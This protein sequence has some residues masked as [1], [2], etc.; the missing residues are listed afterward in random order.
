LLLESDDRVDR[1]IA[2]WFT[3]HRGTWRG[4]ATE[5]IAALKTGADGACDSYSQPAGALYAH[6]QSH[7]QTLR[8]LGVDVLLLA[9]FPRMVSL[10]PC[11][12][13]ERAKSS[14]SDASAS[15]DFS[16]QPKPSPPDAG[17]A[18]GHMVNDK[19]ADGDGSEDHVFENSADVLFGIVQMQNGIREQ[20]LDLKSAM[21]WVAVRAQELTG[22]SGV[23]V[24]LLQQDTVVFPA[25]V[26]IAVTMAGLP[27]L[28]NL[29]QSCIQNGGV[30]PVPDA[31]N[32]TVVGSS[33]R[34]E[35]VKSLIVVPIFRNREIAG[36]IEIFFKETRSFSNS[37][38]MTLELIADVV[39]EGLAS[40]A[41]I[42]AK[43]PSTESIEPQGDQATLLQARPSVSQYVNSN[44]APELS[45]SLESSIPRAV[46]A[47]AA[48]PVPRK[49]VW[50]KCLNWRQRGPS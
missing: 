30:L 36:A 4:T 24:G 29:F 14:P 18:A 13:D 3:L 33:C 20:G 22:S 41:Q 40:A 38:V 39:S 23:A 12:K 5:L 45:L 7:Q 44:T 27:S 35:G 17:E 49:R 37:D 21:D 50:S 6:L 34:R 48:V 26:G 25:R 46:A 31:Q 11:Q 42:E 47:L 9:G 28:A 32:D 1:A 43:Q 19:H 8:S 10:R 15:K 16:D 2:E